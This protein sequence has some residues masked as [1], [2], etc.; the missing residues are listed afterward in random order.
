MIQELA[1]RYGTMFVPDTDQ[2]QYW[3][4]LSIRASP[5]DE[6]IALVC[7]LL[8]ERPKGTVIDVGANFGCWSLPLSECAEEVFAFEPQKCCADLLKRSV[9]ANG[10]RNI[11]VRNKAAGPDHAIASVSK[12]DINSS[13]NFGGVSLIRDNEHPDAPKE[14]VMVQPLDALEV[15]FPVTFIKIDVEGGEI[16]VLRG[17]SRLIEKHRP[18]MFMEVDHPEGNLPAIEEFL[19]RNNYAYDTYQGNYLCMPL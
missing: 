13:G 6:F 8:S 19:D 10:I 3:W 18:I 14:H 9:E 5:E 1:T 2:G 7:K 15:R 11:Y 17:A 16:G 12:L 4:L